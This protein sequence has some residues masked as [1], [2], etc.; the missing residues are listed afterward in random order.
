M[1]FIA[2]VPNQV[3]YVQGVNLG[4]YSDAEKLVMMFGTKS[5]NGQ[6]MVIPMYWDLVDFKYMKMSIA[7]MDSKTYSWGNHDRSLDLLIDN[8]EDAISEIQ[9]RLNEPL[10][11][12]LMFYDR[13]TLASEVVKSNG[14]SDFEGDNLIKKVDNDRLLAQD[15]LKIVAKNYSDWNIGDEFSGKVEDFSLDVYSSSIDKL[16][17]PQREKMMSLSSMV[18]RLKK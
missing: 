16:E 4:L 10:L 7:Q 9:K 2:Y 18:F 3:A 13:S 15:W 14:L 5:V 1:G 12:L 8:Q 17:I 11:M 6:R